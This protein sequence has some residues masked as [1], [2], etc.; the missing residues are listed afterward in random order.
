[1]DIA[2]TQLASLRQY[3]FLLNDRRQ[4][5]SHQ[6]ETSRA[7]K[8]T[9]FEPLHDVQLIDSNS[10]IDGANITRESSVGTSTAVYAYGN[11]LLRKDGEYPMFDA[12]G[13]ER[14]VTNSSQTATGT[15]NYDAFG[16]TV[17]TSGSSSNSNMYGARSG[18]RNDGNAGLM[19]CLAP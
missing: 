5:H 3:R 7:G 13:N 2:V 14:T 12:Q 19:H 8:V 10:E 18:Y 11:G 17:G 15:I 6:V 16:N 9:L 1:M 4:V